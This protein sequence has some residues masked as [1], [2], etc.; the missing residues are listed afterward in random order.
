MRAHESFRPNKR[1]SLNSPTLTLVWSGLRENL[2]IAKL[3]YSLETLA[4][5][6][7]KIQKN[8]TK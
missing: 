5:M 2:V 6:T 8:L 1:E 4:T 3:K 7:T